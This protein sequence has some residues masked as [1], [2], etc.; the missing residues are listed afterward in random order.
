MGKKGVSISIEDYSER[1]KNF[2]LKA[3]KTK[4]EL[5]LLQA[6][7]KGVYIP[8]GQYIYIDAQPTIFGDRVTGYHVSIEPRRLMEFQALDNTGKL[9][10][11]RPF[12]CSKSY[13][14]TCGTSRLVPFIDKLMDDLLL[15]Y[16]KANPKKKGPLL[17]E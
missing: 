4:V 12:A 16:L 6:G 8:T 1:D 13:G 11:Y 7:I 3:I 2:P 17:S 9:V 10:T 15:D 14:G 5:R